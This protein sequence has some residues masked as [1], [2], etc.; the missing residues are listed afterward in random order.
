MTDIQ[1][2][3][4]SVAQLAG[5]GITV[6]GGAA[7][8]YT[9]RQT[10]VAI[11]R[12]AAAAQAGGGG[13]DQAA[14]LARIAAL[15][16]AAATP[17]GGETLALAPLTAVPL[18]VLRPAGYDTLTP[19]EVIS[20]LAAA[21]GK[22]AAELAEGLAQVVGGRAQMSFFSGSIDALAQAARDVARIHEAAP[23]TFEG[24]PGDWS[25]A[26]SRLHDLVVAYQSREMD[27]GTPADGGGGAAN[28]SVMERRALEATMTPLSATK[29]SG[30]GA[31]AFIIESLASSEVAAA[32]AIA[33]A[34]DDAVDERKRLA[35]APYGGAAL[36]HVLSDGTIS[37]KLPGKGHIAGRIVRARE[38]SEAAVAQ[39][40][41][42]GMGKVKAGEV[43]DESKALACSL[44]T[45]AVSFTSAVKLLAATPAATGQVAN[46]LK[47]G[48]G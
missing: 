5:A 19:A 24:K 48:N 21:R 17:A 14:L 2:V 30:H 18:A 26:A 6:S 46:R 34:C 33:P 31:A 47:R 11:A 7:G 32:E 20:N 36:R 37:G 27:G 41:S 13:A 40:I 8:T 15:E 16:A 45:G 43:G 35:A 1:S 10:A 29:Q 44:H 42:K 3:A 23:V 39:R 22:P 4:Q 9:A 38:R 25:E 12:A 28:S